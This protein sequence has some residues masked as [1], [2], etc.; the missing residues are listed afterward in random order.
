MYSCP[1]PLVR[2][3]LKAMARYDR[4]GR[5]PARQRIIIG[6]L[7]GFY[8]TSLHSALLARRPVNLADLRAHINDALDLVE[9]LLVK[10][11][12]ARRREEILYLPRRDAEMR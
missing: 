6:G 5:V 11:T 8:L 4:E 2:P 10:H 12:D 7:S 9:E 3:Y 1:L